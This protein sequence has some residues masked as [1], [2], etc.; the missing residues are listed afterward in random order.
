MPTY[1]VQIGDKTHE[2]NASGP[3]S[4]NDLA[5]L[6]GPAPA[7]APAPAL[8]E[9]PKE[10]VRPSVKAPRT[11]RP[12]DDGETFAD[13]GAFVNDI[14]RSGVKTL[15]RAGQAVFQMLEKPVAEGVNKL[16]GRQVMS[17]HG[18][19]DAIG[20][21]TDAMVGKGEINPVADVI[22]Q[23]GA[24]AVP[25]SMASKAA[26]I[27]AAA[28]PL[29]T[30]LASAGA[31]GGAVSMAATPAE[32]EKDFATEKA[33]QFGMGAVVGAGA[34]AAGEVAKKGIDT[35][36]QLYF[37]TAG[38]EQ[39]RLWDR[40]KDLGFSIRPDQARQDSS[41]VLQPG[42]GQTEALA[43][44][45]TANN[46]VTRETGEEAAAVTPQFLN[47]A[48][49]RLGAGYDAVY[50]PGVKYKVDASAI[51]NLQDFAAYE[52]KIGSPWLNKQAQSAAN[53][54][55]GEF[56]AL[57]GQSGAATV[58][59]VKI[60]AE[61]IQRLRNE[62]SNAARNTNDKIDKN[63]IW[64]VI[65]S[66]DDS[67]ARNH[68]A[69]AAQ[70]KELAPKYQTLLTLD[71]AA[72]KG[73]IDPQG[74]VSLADL[75]RMLRTSEDKYVR[76][77]SNH[78]LQEAGQIGESFGI[79]SV[80]QGRVTSGKGLS[81]GDSSDAIPVTRTG[82]VRTA[83][84]HLKPDLRGTHEEFMKSGGPRQMTM[85]DAVNTGAVSGMVAPPVGKAMEDAS[86]QRTARRQRLMKEAGL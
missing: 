23:T 22:G 27:A 50:A 62:L 38:A 84:A 61:D 59:A 63:G 69:V 37:G 12:R 81:S 66:I 25:F 67:V 86:A 76:G 7:P 49:K 64:E 5:S 44:Q 53:R 71:K 1:E 35:A 85:E 48:H 82:V 83:V 2:V 75:G 33:K 16:A 57:Q 40:A 39:K 15:G 36:K 32:P 74:N 72:A 77:T 17:G 47:D 68:P 6:A 45:K 10:T 14:A 13:A 28:A 31:T 11:F 8:A 4:D 21:A 60:D 54:I 51:K 43:N 24:L 65:K 46:M 34:Q 70:L 41:R 78:P 9:A 73:V 19:S 30:R 80:G 20:A 3:L 56:E 52:D 79:R 18:G 42:L 55:V 29:A 58:K 26:P